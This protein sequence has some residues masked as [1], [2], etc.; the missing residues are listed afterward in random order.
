MLAHGPM[1]PTPALL[2]LATAAAL[3]APTPRAHAQELSVQ[4]RAA[5]VRR[6]RDLAA[7][8]ERNHQ[9]LQRLLRLVD[10][11]ETQR[12]HAGDASARRDA[13]RA[14]EALVTRAEDVRTRAREC[15]GGAALPTVG[16]QVVERPPPPDAA[17]DAVA[18]S[19]GSI[20]EIE[21]DARLGS[22]IHVE[23]AQQVDGQG[24]VDSS[25]IRAAVRAIGPRL[26]RCYERYL[27]RGSVQAR[28]LDLVFTLSGSGRASSV[29]V[30]RSGFSDAT[31]ERCVRAAG[32]RI[33][34]SRGPAGGA[35]IFSYTLR[36][37]R[38]P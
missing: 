34:A 4:E 38:Q 1:R 36:F 10:Q 19:G 11:A 21:R 5:A 35:A 14:I 15:L 25:V 26:D 30:E 7:C 31:F 37:G 12:D 33:R 32:Q 8:V 16:T 9:Q 17:A 6:V 24:R 3:T 13:Q 29:Q 27:D 2:V 23:R 28:R 18:Q 22:N 20:H